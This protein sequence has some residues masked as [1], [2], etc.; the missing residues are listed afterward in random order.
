MLADKLTKAAV[1]HDAWWR[2]AFL[3]VSSLTSPFIEVDLPV[4]YIAVRNEHRLLGGPL[5]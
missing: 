3:S 4:C 2:A 1:L 5:W